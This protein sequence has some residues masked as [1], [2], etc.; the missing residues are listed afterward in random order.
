MSLP[1]YV[2]LKMGAAHPQSWIWGIEIDTDVG[3]KDYE[4]VGGVKNA[5]K[6]ACED[7]D[8]AFPN[9][10]NQFRCKRASVGH[11]NV[12]GAEEYARTI[13]QILQ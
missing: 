4:R 12:G 10:S 13:I 8:S 9:R 2:V 7:T 3:P 6:E 1:F 11:P 5:R